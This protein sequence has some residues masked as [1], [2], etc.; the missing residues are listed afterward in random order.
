M[1]NSCPWTAADKDELEQVQRR[2]VN[3]I[4]ELSGKTY[5]EQSER[6]ET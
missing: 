3:M 2:A 5:G 6:T 1:F 4:S